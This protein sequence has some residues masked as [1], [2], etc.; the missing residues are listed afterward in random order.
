MEITESVSFNMATHFLIKLCC[1]VKMCIGV[2]HCKWKYLQNHNSMDFFKEKWHA[3]ELFAV[4]K[5]TKLG[6]L[7]EN[8]DGN[9]YVKG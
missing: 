2:F 4:I 3:L 8:R 1:V 5:K 9:S 7:E 6:Y